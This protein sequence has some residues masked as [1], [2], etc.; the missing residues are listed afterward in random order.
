MF[1][2]F[3]LCFPESLQLSYLG[4]FVGQPVYGIDVESV[5]NKCSLGSYL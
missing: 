3:S 4:S 5:L 2:E 1:A